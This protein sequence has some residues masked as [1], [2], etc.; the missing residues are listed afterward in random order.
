[1]KIL[2]KIA[3]F[4]IFEISDGHKIEKNDHFENSRIIFLYHLE[5]YLHEQIWLNMTSSFLWVRP[6]MLK[7]AIFSVKGDFPYIS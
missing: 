5:V 3:T 7:I 4:R 2:S 6:F 1:M